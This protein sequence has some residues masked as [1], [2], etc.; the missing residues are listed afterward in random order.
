MGEEYWWVAGK[1]SR[2][3]FSMVRNRDILQNSGIQSAPMS[4]AAGAIS[5]AGHSDFHSH[6]TSLTPTPV[7]CQFST[8]QTYIFQPAR[9]SCSTIWCQ[10]RG[11]PSQED[12]W[13]KTR[14]KN[15]CQVRCWSLTIYFFII[16]MLLRS[17]VDAGAHPEHHEVNVLGLLTNTRYNKEL[18]NP[19]P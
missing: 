2:V 7:W 12:Q 11:H 10:G 6:F 8:I 1:T 3:Q 19:T 17:K 18:L 13:V 16:T 5:A 9:S 4:R 15:T 14:E